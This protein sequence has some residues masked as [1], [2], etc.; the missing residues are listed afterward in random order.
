MSV[1]NCVFSGIYIDENLWRF[2]FWAERLP[3]VKMMHCMV[4]RR[5]LPGR[6]KSR[7]VNESLNAGLATLIADQQGQTIK[8]QQM[9]DSPPFEGSRGTECPN[10]SGSERGL[11]H[12]GGMRNANVD[13]EKEE[14]KLGTGYDEDSSFGSLIGPLQRVCMGSRK[15]YSPYPK[16]SDVRE[17]R[18]ASLDRNDV[19]VLREISLEPASA[20]SLSFHCK[21][22]HKDFSDETTE[23]F[24]YISLD[25]RLINSELATSATSIGG[26][27]GE[28]EAQAWEDFEPMHR[29]LIVA[30]SAAAAAAAKHKNSREINRLN[31]TVTDR[32]RNW[33]RRLSTEHVPL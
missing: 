30:V 11:P 28:K 9:P 33:A 4:S 13:R 24:A 6:R 2:A 20:S 15:Q 27:L 23:K 5:D 7:H 31:K 26:G 29:V 3:F 12:C 19:K 16:V 17:A 25:G 14:E 8:Q 1:I 21:G 22:Q 32:V 18:R 10:F